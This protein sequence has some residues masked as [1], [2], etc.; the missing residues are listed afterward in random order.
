M[1]RLRLLLVVPLLATACVEARKSENP[2]SPT[3]AG[4]IAGVFITQPDTV[5][6]KDNMAVPVTNQPITLVLRNAES[7]GVRP[8]H[9]R[10]ELAVDI[11]FNNKIFVR[12]DI[13]PGEG[14]TT[15]RLPDALAPERTYYW[16]ARAEDGANASDYSGFA[17]FRVFTP[18]VIQ[19]PVLQNPVN[20]VET[21]SVQPEFAIGNA[22]RSGPAGAIGYE[23]ELS[24]SVTFANNLAI[25][26]VAEQPGVT[27][28]T[29]V[30]PAGG[31]YFWRARAFDPSVVGPWSDTQAFRTPR[32]I[33][34]PSPGTPP[35]ANCSGVTGS[36]MQTLECLRAGYPHPMSATDRGSLMNATAWT[37]RG[38][39]WGM[40]LKLSGNRCPQPNTGT[41]ISC[42]ILVHG[43]T[44]AVYDVLIDEETPTF[45][46]KGPISSMSNFVAPVQP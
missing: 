15:V 40:H 11:D 16:R 10:F 43:P 42:D 32:A 36:V 3:I 1:K 23:I 38:D 22:P 27:R 33:S 25:W 31:Q 20:N 45:I 9:Y 35:P 28:F 37:H 26:V 30:L 34:L 12:A 13:A 5:E 4:P 19:K 46:Y 7:N 21:S 18:I 17:F 39:G 14:R 29:Q 8:L 24:D 2:L 41:S 44:G 6:P